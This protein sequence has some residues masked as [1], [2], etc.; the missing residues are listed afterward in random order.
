MLDKIFWLDLNYAQLAIGAQLCGCYFSAILFSEISCKLNSLKCLMDIVDLFIIGN[1]IYARNISRR[2]E[3][4]QLPLKSLEGT[5]IS[6]ILLKV[7]I[8]LKDHYFIDI[9]IFVR[10][11]MNWEILKELKGA[12]ARKKAPIL[13]FNLH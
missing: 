9:E 8:P 5:D 6:S 4:F 12:V 10:Y 2:Q 3:S 7:N 1:G 13:F 11:L